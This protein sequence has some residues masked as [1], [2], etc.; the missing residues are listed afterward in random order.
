MQSSTSKCKQ[1]QET[2]PTDAKAFPH[3]PMHAHTCPHMPTY[4]HTCPS[5]PPHA[6]ICPHTP[7]HARTCQHRPTHAQALFKKNYTT[8]NC[9]VDNFFGAAFQT[10]IYGF[11]DHFLQL[12]LFCFLCSTKFVSCSTKV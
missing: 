2:M 11:V 7:K 12:Y 4:A 9:I 1:T 8:F 3:T 5:T 10:T 6:H